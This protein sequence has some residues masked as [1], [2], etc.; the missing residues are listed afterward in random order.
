MCKSQWA[1]TSTAGTLKQF[2]Q[3]RVGYLEKKKLLRKWKKEDHIFYD[4]IEFL[5]NN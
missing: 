2:L 5:K 3:N 1:L 4:N